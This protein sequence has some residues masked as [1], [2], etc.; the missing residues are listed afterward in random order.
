MEGILLSNKKSADLPLVRTLQHSIINLNKISKGNM[1]AITYI[2][3]I[4]FL[5]YFLQIQALFYFQHGFLALCY[6][7][8]GKGHGFG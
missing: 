2:M 1:I 8:Y 4:L 3:N 7:P 5:E 6:L